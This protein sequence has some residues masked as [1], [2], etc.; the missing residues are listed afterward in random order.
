MLIQS[1]GLIQPRSQ[2]HN[3]HRE[4]ETGRTRRARR[5]RACDG[6]RAMRCDVRRRGATRR[7]GKTCIVTDCLI[8]F[9][10][11]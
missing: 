3:Y 2:A 6:P 8:L 10:Q 11:V 5:E 9:A 4:A 1:G 7:V